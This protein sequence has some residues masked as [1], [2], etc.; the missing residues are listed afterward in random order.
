M[1]TYDLWN[2]SGGFAIFFFNLTQFRA[3]Q[4]SSPSRLRIAAG[5]RRSAG[6]DG[7]FTDDRF[8]VFVDIFLISAFQYI[9]A[10]VLNSTLGNLADTGAN[11][12][13][14]LLG[15]PIIFFIYCK[16]TRTDLLNLLD[17]I[18]PGFPLALFFAKMACFDAGCC[19]GI[20][21]HAPFIADHFPTF[22]S[23]LV[24]ANVG[25]LL[26]L[27]LMSAKERLKLGTAYPVYMILYSGI[28]FFTEFLREEENILWIFKTY[29]F[30][31]LAGLALGILEYAL[32]VR[33]GTRASAHTSKAD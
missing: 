8:W 30:F 10:P 14:L 15:A 4:Q 25:I 17:L 31:C 21:W 24:E 6:H 29:H 9:P 2:L 18:A 12:F 28:R 22:P 11:Y 16:I 1:S 19:G 3:H 7:F 13:G 26:F 5:R 27:F 33:V 23:Q 20:P 32:A